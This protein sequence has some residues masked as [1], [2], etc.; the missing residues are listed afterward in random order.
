MAERR[1][2]I[3][4]K[5]FASLSRNRAAAKTI[6]DEFRVALQTLIAGEDDEIPHARFAGM[7]VRDGVHQVVLEIPDIAPPQSTEPTPAGA[8]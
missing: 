8:A 1:I 2:T 5:Q 7:D 4:A 6:D 3:K